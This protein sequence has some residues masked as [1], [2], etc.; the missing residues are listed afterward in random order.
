MA[1]RSWSVASS[2]NSAGGDTFNRRLPSELVRLQYL[3]ARPAQTQPPRR[4]I[5][6]LSQ[7]V[8]W[9]HA[10]A[11]S[12]AF[13]SQTLDPGRAQLGAIAVSFASQVNAQNA[14]RHY[15]R[16][17]QGG[18]LF[19]VG[20]P[21][22]MR[23][24]K[25]RQCVAERVVRESCTEPTTGDYTLAFNGTTYTLTD[26][27]TGSVVGSATNLSQPING[28]NFLDHGH[29][30]PWRLVH[31][32]ADPRRAEQLRDR[33]DGRLGH[34]GR[35]A[36]SGRG[37]RRPTPAPALSRRARSRPATPCRTDDHADIRRHGSHRFPGRLDGDRGRFPGDHLF[38]YR[39]RRPWCRIRRATGA[40]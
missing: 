26:N 15:A 5:F 9:R 22:S 28:L 2:F 13:R 29:D 21:T 20:G 18:A 19:S 10:S 31:G 17:C 16:G 36:G 6:V 25:H 34:R 1:S 3:K 38:D 12:L 7:Q 33:D 30:G 35:S 39:A 14:T 11:A 4:P 32:P 23:T 24:R 27:P 8:L 37:R 40:S